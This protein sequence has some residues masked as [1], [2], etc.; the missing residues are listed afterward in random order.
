LFDSSSLGR[1]LQ[2][3]GP[4]CPTAKGTGDSPQYCCSKNWNR[5]S[6]QIKRHENFN[7]KHSYDIA[8]SAASRFYSPKFKKRSGFMF[9]W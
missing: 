9:L 2:Q 5:I 1:A 6:D 4:L 8:I 7:G 3:Q